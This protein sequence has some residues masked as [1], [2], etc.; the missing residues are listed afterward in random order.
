[1]RSLI[2]TFLIYLL[3]ANSNCS[4]EELSS[5]QLSGNKWIFESV[6]NEEIVTREA[7]YLQFTRNDSEYI[8]SGF[9]GCNRFQGSAIITDSHIEL[10]P[11]AMT[12]MYCEQTDS[13]ERS[14]VSMLHESLSYE[15]E[16]NKLKLTSSD[17]IIAELYLELGDN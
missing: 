13:L 16:G 1:M 12:R 4:R 5:T 11:L 3:L 17:G 10:S 2:V 9:L 7:P 14:I 6:N 8:I 15:L